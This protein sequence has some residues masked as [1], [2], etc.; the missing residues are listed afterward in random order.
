[1][2][3]YNLYVIFLKDVPGF[4]KNRNLIGNHVGYI[5]QLNKTGVVELC[6]PFIDSDEGMIVLNVDSRKEA[7]SI[8]KKDPF[9][10]AGAKTY[11]IR[12]WLIACEENDYLRP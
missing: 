1:M 2:I 11:E 9:I 5:E 4:K 3:N 6:G 10:I 8:A 7:E 12:T